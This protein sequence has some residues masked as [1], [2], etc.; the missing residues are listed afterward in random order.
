MKSLENYLIIIGS[1]LPYSFPADY[2]KQTARILSQ[3]NQIIIFLWGEA[4]SLKEIA[5]ESFLKKKSFQLLRKDKKII[6]FTPIHFVPFKRFESIRQVNLKLN[7]VFLSLY[8]RYKG[9]IRLKKI[10]WIFNYELYNLPKML[11]TSFISLYDCVEYFSSINKKINEEIKN[12]EKKLIRNVDWFFVD[13]LT[14]KNVFKKYSPIITPKGFDLQTFKKMN[15]KKPKSIS[16]KIM[17]LLSKKPIIGYIGSINYRLDYKLLINLAKNHP[18]WNFV[19]VGRKQNRNSEDRFLNTIFWQNKLFLLKNVYRI[20][21][22]PKSKIPFI[23]SKF[24]VCLIPYNIDIDFNR[25]SGPMKLLEYF[26]LGKPVISTPFLEA[27]RWRP[28]VGVVKNAREFSLAIDSVLKRGWPKEYKKKQKQLTINNSWQAKI[29]KINKL[30]FRKVKR[31]NQ[32]LQKN[33]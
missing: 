30:V 33:E 9:L 14:L 16:K 1:T 3:K 13:C 8:L 32:D 27:K 12:K 28:Y 10:L 21:N 26:Y 23:I 25:Y 31:N 11:N 22:Q 4:L 2:V 20:G 15:I 24:N 18:H 29:D 17:N 6:L 19:F 5:K 7:T